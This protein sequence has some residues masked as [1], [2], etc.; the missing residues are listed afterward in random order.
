MQALA[1]QVGSG[2]KAAEA[3]LEA[4]WQRIASKYGCK[5]E[6]QPGNNQHRPCP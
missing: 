1:I 5:D 6:D 4:E 3:H 2:D